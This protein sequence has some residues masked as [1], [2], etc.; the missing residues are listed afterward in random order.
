M[1]CPVCKSNTYETFS[2]GRTKIKFCRSCNLY[3]TNDHL[4]KVQYY[5]TNYRID[6]TDGIEN[7]FRRLSLIPQHYKL[8]QELN[9]YLPQG[10]KILDFGCGN[11]YFIDEIR[12]YGFSCFGVEINMVGKK[13]AKAI[14]LEVKSELIDFEIIF[15]A[16]TFW[17]SLEHLADPK[18]ILEQTHNFLSKDGYIFIRVPNFASFWSKILKD[19]WIW[20]QPQNHISHFSIASLKKLLESSNFQIVSAKQQRPNNFQT[21]LFFLLSILMTP[22]KLSYKFIIRKIIAKIVEW[23]TGSEIFVIAKRL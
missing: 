1:N 8:I 6:S 17:H 13:Y 2:W 3:F 5:K 16:I 23:I 11:G 12:R 19:R 14:G 22:K 21:F 10:A 9:K 15:D 18:E 4:D 7:N 20:Y